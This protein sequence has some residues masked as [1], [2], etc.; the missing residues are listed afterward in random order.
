MKTRKLGLLLRIKT[1]PEAFKPIA[2]DKICEETMRSIVKTNGIPDVTF[3][4][5]V[6]GQE[7]TDEV[8]QR[9]GN[10]DGGAPPVPADGGDVPVVPDGSDLPV[11]RGL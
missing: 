9:N 1:G 11:G 7:K 2:C 10:S 3:D 4:A 6:L 5:D 8:D